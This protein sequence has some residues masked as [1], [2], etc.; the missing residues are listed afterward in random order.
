MENTY[1][2]TA[3]SAENSE[4]IVTFTL[5]DHH[6]SVGLGV[7]LEQVERVLAETEMEAEG[8]EAPQPQIWLK[9]VAVSLL[10]RG[11]GPFRLEDVSAT[12]DAGWLRVSAWYRAGGLAL[13]PLTLV[14]GPVDNPQGAQAFV[15]EVDRRKE[16]IVGPLG[17]LNVLDYWLTWIAAGV[18]LFALFQVIR[19]KGRA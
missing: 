8:E 7:P 12:A 15:E 6:M 3:R 10:E 4:E 14:N 13:A 9:P 2:Y 11:T 16:E 19:R 18:A 1:T 17:S 5:H